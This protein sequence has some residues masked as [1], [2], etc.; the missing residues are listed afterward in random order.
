LPEWVRE[1]IENYRDGAGGKYTPIQKAIP[2]QLDYKI[3]R[4]SYTFELKKDQQW[5]F[6]NLVTW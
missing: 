3:D 5:I 6:L 1:S 2:A 4:V